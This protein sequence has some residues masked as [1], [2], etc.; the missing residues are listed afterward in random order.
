MQNT[1]KSD[2]KWVK[3]VF[4]DPVYNDQ[5]LHFFQEKKIKGVYDFQKTHNDYSETPLSHLKNLAEYLDVADI[6]VKDESYRFGLNAFK[7]MGGIYAVGK[8]LADRLGKKIEEL[9]FQELQ[10]PRVKEELGELTFISATDGNH[11]RGVAWAA[12]ELGHRSVIYMPKGSARVRLEAIRN[13]GAVAHITELNYDDAVRMCA[14]VA[15]ENGWIMVQDTAWKGYDHI[16][17]WIMQGYASMGKEIV[18]QL[19]RDGGEQPTHIFLQAGVGSFAAAITAYMVQHYQGNPPIVVVVEPDQADCYYKSFANKEGKRETVTGMMDTIMAGLACGEPNTRAFRILKQY[20]KAAF[21]C[22]DSIAALGMRI[23]GSPMKD[24][25][26]V[27]SGESGS[28]PL[29]L[30]YYLRK[31]KENQK[32]CVE[33]SLDSESRIL[34]ISTE[35]DTDPVHYRKVVWE[36]SCPLK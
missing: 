20:A 29:G 21:S 24:D 4:Y 32:V 2:I 30:L 18:E 5:E 16:P 11:G 14:D 34:L 10:S 31:F 36:G 27:V 15:T 6:R 28:A 35:G 1:I 9:S 17:L 25:P 12:R 33:L 19:L 23:Y 13:E 3:N 7:V 22:D 26:H 8:Y